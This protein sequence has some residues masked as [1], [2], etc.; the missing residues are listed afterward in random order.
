MSQMTEGQYE[1]GDFALQNGQVLRDAF[2][3][4]AT[5]GDLNDAADNVIVFPTWYTGTHHGVDPYIGEGKALDPSS[6]SL[7][8]R[9]CSR[10]GIRRLQAT[11]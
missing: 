11:P 9:T 1:L 3:G 8:S 5:Y 10:M 2:I 7:S 4:Y 6:I